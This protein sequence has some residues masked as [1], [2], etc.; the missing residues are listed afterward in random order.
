L[1]RSNALVNRIAPETLNEATNLLC[2]QL[3][4]VFPQLPPAA[5][6]DRDRGVAEVRTITDSSRETVIKGIESKFA[7]LRNQHIPRD[8]INQEMAAY[9]SAQP[10]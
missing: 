3:P 10:V 6:A 4:V 8:Q 9:M 1:R 5:E 2:A 7:Q